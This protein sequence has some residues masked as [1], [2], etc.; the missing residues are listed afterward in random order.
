MPK[1]FCTCFW[2]REQA[3]LSLSK[4]QQEKPRPRGQQHVPK[5]TTLAART[6]SSQTPGHRQVSCSEWFR[7]KTVN[8]E[9][10]QSCLWVS[11]CDD[12]EAQILPGAD[13]MTENPERLL[14]RAQRDPDFEASS[15]SLHGEWQGAAESPREQRQGWCLCCTHKRPLGCDWEVLNHAS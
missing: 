15:R 10:S 1:T 14:I 11:K 9:Y 13:C 7:T 2:D 6:A 5:P 12:R 4:Y 3:S 8:S